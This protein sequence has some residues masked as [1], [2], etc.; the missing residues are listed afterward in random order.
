MVDQMQAQDGDGDEEFWYRGK[1]T[2]RRLIGWG[3]AG[4]GARSNDAGAGAVAGHL[5]PWLRGKFQVPNVDL[6]IVGR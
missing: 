5:R 1:V 2:R 4:A 3:A 6:S